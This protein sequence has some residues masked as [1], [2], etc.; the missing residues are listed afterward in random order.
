MSKRIVSA[1]VALMLA[2][3][4]ALAAPRPTTSPEGDPLG[5]PGQAQAA[6]APTPARAPTPVRTPP[7]P[8][9]VE[10]LVVTAK[11]LQPPVDSIGSFVSGISAPSAKGR[12]ARWD[13]KICPGVTGL[14]KEYAQHIVD[15]I[16]TV[17]VA[18]GLEVGAPGCKANLLVVATDDAQGLARK[19]VDDNP[20]IFGRYEDGVTR[21]RVALKDFIETPRPVRWWHVTFTQGADGQRYTTGGNLTVRSM[22]RVR[23][24]TRDDFDHVIVIMDV[25]RIGVINFDALAD[26]ITMVGLAQIDPAANTAGVAT[27]LNLFSDRERGVAPVNRMTDWDVAYLKGLYTVRREVIR[28]ARQE[29]D[30]TRGMTEQLTAPSPEAEPE[31]TAPADPKADD[32][33]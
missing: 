23:A 26:Y 3:Q 4:P 18:V 21:G 15:R 33:D 1:M 31:T 13:R 6:P 16:A 9:T 24:T 29:R 30:I 8:A 25:S 22:G 19:A 32:Q 12:L 11:P 14:K 28:G 27:I 17:A 20:S 2:A 7:P 10:G 5:A